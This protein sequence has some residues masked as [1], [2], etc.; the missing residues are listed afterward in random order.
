M[1]VT[2]CQLGDANADF[3]RVVLELRQGNF[4]VG[5]FGYRQC[6][7][8]SGN[9]PVSADTGWPEVS[10]ATGHRVAQA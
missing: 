1:V 10:L 5:R 3:V 4:K 2:H 8:A 7:R 6:A 9:G